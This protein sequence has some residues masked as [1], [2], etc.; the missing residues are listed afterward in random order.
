MAPTRRQFLTRSSALLAAPAIL[1]RGAA[2][3]MTEIH[4]RMPLVLPPTLWETWLEAT[5]RDAPYLAD[6]IERA[7]IPS[8]EARTVTDR[9]NNVRNEGEDLLAPGTVED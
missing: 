8:L 4:D 1:T 7:G 3:R 9:V 6:V 2:G 5:E